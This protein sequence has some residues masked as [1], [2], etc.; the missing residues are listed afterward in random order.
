MT[1]KFNAE[2]TTHELIQWIR[3]WFEKNGTSCNAIIGISGG[4]DS[5]VVA[6]LCVAALG[7]NRVIGIKMPNG[8]QP[9]EEDADSIIQHL[10]IRGYRIDIA[11]AYDAIIDQVE[12][13]A[14]HPSNQSVINL[15]PRLR[16]SV[17]Y[18]MAQS[19]NGRVS[20]NSNLSERYIG[21]ST[22][23]GDSV[24]DFAP[25]ANLTVQEVIAI[26]KVLGLP[27]KLIEKTPADGLSKKTDEETFGFT[28]DELDK[29]I[30]TGS[31]ANENTVKQIK[32]KHEKNR[33][34]LSSIPMFQP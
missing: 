4:K 22:R 19:L 9:D 23:W 34:K 24:G 14:I 21:Y 11:N 3:E 32:T 17:L 18:C 5:S 13:V 12:N 29:Y 28:Y 16:M 8:Y 15:A 30:R 10:G 33:F 27:S 20:N 2:K 1:Y 31:C 6:A 26:G 25:L 7:K